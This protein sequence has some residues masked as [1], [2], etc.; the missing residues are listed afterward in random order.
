MPTATD[1]LSTLG[2]VVI[3]TGSSVATT[4]FTTYWPYIL[5]FGVLLTLAIFV[6]RVIKVGR[7]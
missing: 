7:R 2:T 6:K 5:V 4:V 1:T 3:N